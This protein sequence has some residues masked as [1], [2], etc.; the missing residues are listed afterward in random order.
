ML[1]DPKKMPIKHLLVRWFSIRADEYQKT[2][3][4]SLIFGIQIR[5]TINFLQKQKQKSRTY[6]TPKRFVHS[7]FRS[8][9]IFVKRQSSY[10]TRF[11][12]DTQKHDGILLFFNS[13]NIGEFSSRM[14]IKKISP[15]RLMKTIRPYRWSNRC[16]L[17][18]GNINSQHRHSSHVFHF[19]FVIRRM[20]C[21]IISTHFM[22]FSFHF[23]SVF[24]NRLP[25]FLSLSL[26]YY[27]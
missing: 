24:R 7:I 19:R 26:I 15:K 27:I 12:Y 17:I 18:F 5:V 13:T 22:Y 4:S 3:I 1:N 16:K 10:D 21:S 14:V 11:I 25:L 6:Q 20:L 23:I 9:S 2:I 8:R